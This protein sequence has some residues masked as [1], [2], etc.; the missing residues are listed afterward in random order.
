M[1][2][3]AGG[4]SS[5]TFATLLEAGNISGAVNLLQPRVQE[6]ARGLAANAAGAAGLLEYH[7]QQAFFAIAHG[8]WARSGTDQWEITSEV[9]GQ[10]EGT[11]TR[12]DF[13]ITVGNQPARFYAFEFGVYRSTWKTTLKSAVIDK[14]KQ[15]N[16]YFDVA[17]N[18]PATLITAVIWS[19]EGE[20]LS[21]AG[22]YSKATASQKVA[23]LLSERCQGW[24]EL[25]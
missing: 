16:K 7:L 4:I 22:P 23:V 17:R 21:I 6:I 20:I 14:L 1:P 11:S 25:L 3:F 5:Q 24:Q 10:R 19:E 18:E 9:R 8:L 2:A 12:A 15:A 13:L